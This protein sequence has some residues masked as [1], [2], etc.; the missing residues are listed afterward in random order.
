MRLAPAWN[1]TYLSA[2]LSCGETICAIYGAKLCPNYVVCR[3]FFSL[4]PC[5]SNW[6][7][8]HECV[9]LVSVSLDHPFIVYL[10]PLSGL[11]LFHAFNLIF[12]PSDVQVRFLLQFQYITDVNTIY[13]STDKHVL[14]E[15]LSRNSRFLLHLKSGRLEMRRVWKILRLSFTCSRAD[16][17]SEETGWSRR[18]FSLD[19]WKLWGQCIVLYITGYACR[20]AYS[21]SIT[22]MHEYFGRP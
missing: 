8:N 21:M 12:L 7:Y 20:D 10:L 6:S 2:V 22:S 13:Y 18:K 15:C 17:R 4:C 9:G 16:W 14:P 11:C 3:N 19:L 1:D 5:L